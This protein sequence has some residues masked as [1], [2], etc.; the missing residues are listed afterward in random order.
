MGLILLGIPAA[1]EVVFVIVLF[2]LLNQAETEI[3]QETHSKEVIAHAHNLAERITNAAISIGAYGYSKSELAKHSYEAAVSAMKRELKELTRL[4][5]N[6]PGQLKRLLSLSEIVDTALK[7]IDEARI[8]IE[9]SSSLSLLGGDTVMSDNLEKLSVLVGRMQKQIDALVQAEQSA[10]KD[11]PAKRARSRQQLLVLLVF[12]AVLNI[13]LAIALAGFFSR[14]VTRRHLILV[15]NTRR[16]AKAQE[17]HPPLEGADEIAQ[18]DAVFHNMVLELAAADQFKKELIA[19]VS[20]ELR[21]PLTSIDA[22]LTFLEAGGMG[23]LS[24]GVN[25][26][27]KIAETEVQRLIALIND[28]L[29][30]E[31]MEAG[32]FEMSFSEVEMKEVIERSINAVSGALEHKKLNVQAESIEGKVWADRDRL[33]Q[34]MVNLLSNAIKFSPDG[35]CIRVRSE[36]LGTQIELSVKDEG[37]GISE[38]F[39]KRI[40]QR[41]SQAQESDARVR[42]G[43]GLGL[44]ICRAI[45]SQHNGSIGVE[46]EEG[47][48]ARFWFRI[49]KQANLQIEKLR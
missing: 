13:A 1:F 33:I 5:R 42:G 17:L 30:V 23:E 29:D 6:D 4:L 11:L 31:R 8:S 2:V 24:D 44:T 41:F 9:K 16:L 35:S 48:G 25:Q 15:D 36:D 47:R 34:V 45:V 3:K 37:R 49:P 32:K 46:S 14:V 22:I 38:E 10:H 39:K 43:S 26:R 20:H 27:L 21:A 40:F 18:L 19:M 12:G 28:L 7:T